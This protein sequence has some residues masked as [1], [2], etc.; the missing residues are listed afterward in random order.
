MK[1]IISLTLI[2]LITHTPHVLATQDPTGPHADFPAASPDGKRLLF[3]ST[4]SSPISIWITGTNSKKAS[5]FIQKGT[6]YSADWSPSGKEIVFESRTLKGHFLWIC[7]KHG[8]KHKKLVKGYQPR[9]SP[10]GNKILFLPDLHRSG[11]AILELKTNE[12][13][14]FRTGMFTVWGHS[15]APDSKKNCV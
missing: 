4:E 12:V 8:K 14:K 6:V 13:T 1:I 11:L 9:W 3:Y 7:D 10:D 5:K 2:I 15:W